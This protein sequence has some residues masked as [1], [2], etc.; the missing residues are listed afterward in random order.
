MNRRATIVYVVLLLALVGV[1]YY[2]NNRDKTAVDAE[3]TLTV[4]PTVEVVYLFPAEAGTPSSIRVEA[5]S[6][7]VVEIAHKAE[8]AWMVTQPIEGRAEP[9]AAEAAA[10]QVTTTRILDSVP[11]I[12]PE[13]IGLEVPE[14]VLT[15]KFTG[16]AEQTIYL[17]NVTPSEGGYYA[18]EADG[19]I[20]IVS[21]SAIDALLGLL[22]YPP[23]L[24]TPTP[25]P[26]PPTETTTP[27]ASPPVVDTP[28]GEMVTPQP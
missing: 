20:I 25:S 11:D 3:I 23:Y 13:V 16:G 28:T 8:N 22:Q 7:Q 5:K 4:E 12:D 10:S 26:L 2:L 21:R 15:I 24:E 18:R 9:G 19:E 14:Y 17:G 6:G 27:L 1:Y